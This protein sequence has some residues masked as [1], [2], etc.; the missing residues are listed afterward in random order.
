[1][2]SSRVA[3]STTILRGRHLAAV[4]EP[5]REVELVPL[6][7]GELEVAQTARP[8]A[9]W[10]AS[11]SIFGDLGH[12]LTVAVGV[13]RLGV[14]G[15][16]HHVDEGIQQVLLGLQHP[17]QIE[18]HRRVG[19]D[20]LDARDHFGVEA[21]T[22]PA[23][24]R[25]LTSWRMPTISPFWSVERHVEERSLGAIRPAETLADRGGVECRGRHEIVDRDGLAAAGRL[26]STSG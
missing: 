8:S 5:A 7:V 23:A 11:A 2:V 26:A 19:R 22:S 20:G 16:R 6:V 17:P 25:A 15:P 3:L 4:V 24:D 14:D 18:G 13:G 9:L 10:A 21:V 12:P 1:M